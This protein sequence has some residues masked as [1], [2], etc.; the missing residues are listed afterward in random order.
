M[1]RGGGTGR[2]VGLE[3]RCRVRGVRVRAPSSVLFNT[4]KS[5][6]L[7]ANVSRIIPRY[8]SI[9]TRKIKP[10]QMEFNA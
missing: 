6:L 9:Q 8:R 3:N 5:G 1:R 4:N 2:R 7:R 10:A